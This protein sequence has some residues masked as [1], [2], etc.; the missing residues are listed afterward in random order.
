MLS[1]LRLI[2]CHPFLE[3][4]KQEARMDKRSSRTALVR[5][6]AECS[7]CMSRLSYNEKLS[8]TFAGVAAASGGAIF[9]ADRI[10]ATTDPRTQQILS[11]ILVF[12]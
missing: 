11:C 8:W 10:N 1:C 5:T 3:S 6:H 12:W 9:L 2:M 4:G 7:S